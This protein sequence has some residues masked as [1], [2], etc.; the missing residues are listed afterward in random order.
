M[1]F[2]VPGSSI[3]ELFDHGI[4]WLN[5]TWLLIAVLG[6]GVAGWNGLL[7]GTERTPYILRFDED[8]ANPTYRRVCYA[9]AWNA[10]KSRSLPQGRGG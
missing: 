8:R 10:A 2:L 1:F 9:V 3:F 7:P 5:G 6:T 4:G